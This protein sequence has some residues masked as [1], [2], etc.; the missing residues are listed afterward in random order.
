MGPAVDGLVAL[1][2]EPLDEVVLQFVA[3]MVGAEVHA[4]ASE[5]G[6][7]RG[8]RRSPGLVTLSEYNEMDSGLPKDGFEKF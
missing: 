6:T 8:G 4:H 2:R 5:C 3:G 1:G 7:S